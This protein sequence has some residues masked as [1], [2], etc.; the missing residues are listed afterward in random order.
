MKIMRKKLIAGVC[1][2]LAVVIAASGTIMIKNDRET[3][4]YD[5]QISMEL[6]SIENITVSEGESLPNMD[7][8]FKDTTLVNLDSVKADIQNVDVTVPGEYEIHYTFL[9][10]KGNEREKTVLCSVQPKLEAHV[11][12][13]QDLV[14]DCGTALPPA[15]L[16]YDSYV[17]SVVRDDSQVDIYTPGTYP[18]TY[19]ILGADGTMEDVDYSATVLETVVEPT[20]TPTITPAISEDDSKVPLDEPETGNVQRPAEQVVKT[21]DNTMIL[22][23]MILFVGAAVCIYV[24]KK[25]LIR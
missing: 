23:Y 3:K 9:D 16:T 20:P 11:Y 5:K 18:L 6:D 17:D 10:N 1:I 21:A 8:I 12:G 14:T 19:S 24:T 7:S 13:M 2:S 15:E 4:A 22:P 25:R